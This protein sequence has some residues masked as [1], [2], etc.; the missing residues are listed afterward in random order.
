[1]RVFLFTCSL[2]L[3]LAGQASAEPFPALGSDAARDHLTKGQTEYQLGNWQAAIDHF[4]AG[5]RL[6]DSNSFF[7]N[8]AQ[9]ER[10]AGNLK[11]A[12]WYYERMIAR[13]DGVAGGDQYIE[14][15]RKYIDEIDVQLAAAPHDA[16]PNIEKQG[17]P[18]APSMFTTKRK[19]ALGTAGASVIALSV[20]I[21]F[22]V[23]GSG[24]RSDASALC[25]TTAC[26]HAAEANVLVQR[27]DRSMRDGEILLGSGA[28]L[29]IAAA[30]LWFTGKP[31]AHARAE[32]TAAPHLSPDT[33][34]LDVMVRF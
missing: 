19:I 10:K 22:A 30:I 20:G 31:S 24:L 26:D 8:L 5:E 16:Q 34:G 14:A 32:V 6:E 23:H 25:P 28:A 21:G 13:L 27:G 4:E 15:S 1:M 33:A 7:W 11:K 12:R 3:V 17:A 29:V 2:A 9:A 18:S